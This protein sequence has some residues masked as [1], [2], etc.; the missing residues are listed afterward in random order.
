[1]DLKIKCLQLDLARQKEKFEYIKYYFDFAKKC[2]YNTVMIYLENVVRTEDTLF[3]DVDES[4]SSEEMAEIVEYANSLGLE[5]IP[6]LQNL[7][8]LAGFFK[9]DQFKHFSEGKGRFDV[10]PGTACLSNKDFYPFIDKYIKDVVK[11]FKYSKY[12]NMG[13]DEQFNFAICEKC[14]E[15]IKNGETK[16][17][18][19]LDHILHTHKLI[20]DMGK[21]MLMWDDWFEY[22]DIVDKIPRDIILLSWHYVFMSDE[23]NGHWINRIKK[24][25][26]KLYDKLGIRY[27]IACY[28]HRASSVYNVETLTNYASKHNPYGA[29]TT[30]WCRN[31]SFY[32]GAFPY[33]A[34]AAKLW[35]GEINSEE[36]K[37]KVF[38]D[39]LG[40]DKKLA[41]LILTL[42]VIETTPNFTPLDY[43]VNDTLTFSLY[44][45][46]LKYF[47]KEIKERVIALSGLAKDIATDI[48]DFTLEVY[49][50]TR[51]C[52]LSEKIFDNYDG[53]QMNLPALIDEAKE[54]KAGYQEIYENGKLLWEK[55]RKGVNSRE[56]GFNKKFI[57]RA[58]RLDKIIDGLKK[59]QKKGVLFINFTGPEYYYSVRNRITVKYKGQEECVAYEGPLKPNE[60]LLEISGSFCVRIAIEDKEVEYIKFASF[61][62]G[63]FHPQH[64]RYYANGEKYVADKVE[65]ISGEVKDVEKVLFDDS[66]FAVMG[67]DNG[68][69]YYNDITLSDKVDEIKLYFTPIK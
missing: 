19:F 32:E 46:E 23:P 26:F 53:K 31:D 68:K 37:I 15:R 58:E 16:D 41:E 11:I 30:A 33:M 13:L 42:N 56:D 45:K 17:Q 7:S 52:K 67:N 48:Y 39:L 60:V 29:I 6:Y 69:D 2:G 50:N 66:R 8:Y 1:M 24:D 54:I 28:A 55:Y 62:E 10:V 44:R 38:A 27:M 18:M 22:S 9:Y 4:Y 59:N 3:F 14:R 61:K 21:T 49:L 51:L 65:V 40:G 35:N 5:L 25:W 36:D 47:L 20:T 57:A 63:A 43:G 64:F 34:Y 12:V